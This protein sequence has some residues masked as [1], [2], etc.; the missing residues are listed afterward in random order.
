M[1]PGGLY[2]TLGDWDGVWLLLGSLGVLGVG[3][4]ACKN[5]PVG[6][7]NA[8]SP[9]CTQYRTSPLQ[10]HMA[11]D[12]FYGTLGD[13][14]GVWLLLGSLGSL[15]VGNP[16]CKNGPVGQGNALSHR[17]HPIPYFTITVPYGN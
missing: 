1:A 9:E 5:G 6:G 11:P 15:G 16:A 14:D 17:M 4:P 8:P 7:G 13:W 10:S 3:S 12:G 2:G